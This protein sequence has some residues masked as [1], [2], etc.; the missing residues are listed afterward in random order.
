MRNMW[1]FS[2][3]IG[4]GLILAACATS[5]PYKYYGV[6]LKDQK[7][8]GPTPADDLPLTTCEQTSVDASPCTALITS[9]FLDL[10]K[11]YKDCQDALSAC[12]HGNP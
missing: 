8:L 7:L 1:I 10:K 11:S 3:G 12:Q 6:D 2:L 9:S 4:C 5:F